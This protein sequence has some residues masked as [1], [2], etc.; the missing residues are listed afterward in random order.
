M[1]L[2]IQGKDPLLSPRAAMQKRHR[3]PFPGLIA[4]NAPARTPGPKQSPCVIVLKIRAC[5]VDLPRADFGFTSE[6]C[7]W[8]MVYVR[9]PRIYT[10]GLRHARLT[11]GGSCLSRKRR[12]KHAD[13]FV[14]QHATHP[15]PTE[16][17][18]G[19]YFGNPIW[20]PQLPPG[21]RR[22]R[23]LVQFPSLAPEDFDRVVRDSSAV[24]V[25]LIFFPG[26]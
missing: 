8:N 15:P 9:L 24:R 19:N 1:S 23:A 10:G 16:E 13:F 26:P 22:I 12:K 2:G 6:P 21:C 17:T 14:R 11:R 25:T 3:V 20:N 4:R 5:A 7:V 18:F